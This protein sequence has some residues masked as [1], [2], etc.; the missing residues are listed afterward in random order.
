M[1]AALEIT[2]IP[3]GEILAENTIL[4]KGWNLW[5]IERFKNDRDILNWLAVRTMVTQ[6]AF[7]KHL[8]FMAIKII[9]VLF[10]YSPANIIFILVIFG[11]LSN[12]LPPP[13]YCTP[14]PDL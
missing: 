11:Y 6:T 13:I 3:A 1:A 10:G 14:L 4:C 2:I 5:E 9:T 12:N 7:F 8:F